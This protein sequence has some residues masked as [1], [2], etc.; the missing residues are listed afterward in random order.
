[1]VISRPRG[2]EILSAGFSWR[3][4]QWREMDCLNLSDWNYPDTMLGIPI[5][6]SPFL[7]LLFPSVRYISTRLHG[8]PVWICVPRYFIRK[9]ERERGA[10]IPWAPL[11][12]LRYLHLYTSLLLLP[13]VFFC[14]WPSAPTSRN[15][16]HFLASNTR[17]SVAVSG[18]GIGQTWFTRFSLAD[19]ADYDRIWYWEIDS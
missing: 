17:S 6:L 7:S 14:Y 1:M 19:I 16:N 8:E 15:V 2:S 11:V 4:R 5:N 10:S 12:S 3:N 9:G 18:T 13:P